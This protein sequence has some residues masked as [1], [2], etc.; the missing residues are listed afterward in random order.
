MVVFLIWSV[1]VYVACIVGGCRFMVWYLWFNV[2]G[3]LL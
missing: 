1:L 2:C 3:L